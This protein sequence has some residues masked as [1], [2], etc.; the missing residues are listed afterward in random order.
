MSLRSELE[1]KHFC[2]LCL[3]NDERGPGGLKVS[4]LRPVTFIKVHK[5]GVKFVLEAER[6]WWFSWESFHISKHFCPLI[7]ILF[8]NK[9]HFHT[10]PANFH[11]STHLTPA[12]D[13]LHWESSSVTLDCDRISEVCSCSIW[14][15][16]QVYVRMFIMFS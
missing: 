12:C 11:S 16:C 7:Y 6:L 5:H 2:G 8:L 10:F 15:L 14:S 9:V 4:A 1:I 13:E 3:L